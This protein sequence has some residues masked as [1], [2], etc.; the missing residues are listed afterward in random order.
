MLYFNSYSIIGLFLLFIGL[1]NATADPK[2]LEGT[3]STKSNAVFTGPDFYDPV[4]ELLIEPA[5]PGI[6]FSFTKL[7]S[8]NEGYFE[9]SIYQVTSNAKDP[10]CP[11]A[12]LIF[13]H[14]KYEVLKNNSIVLK[15]FE[16]DGRQ[17]L[18]APCN[19]SKSTYSRYNQTEQY[20][21]FNVYVDEYHGRYR[22]DLYK[23]DGSPFPPFYLSYKPPMMLPTETLNPTEAGSSP[24]NTESTSKRVKRSLENRSKTPAVLKHTRDYDA[25]WWIGVVLIFFGATG[26]YVL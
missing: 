24:Q 22:L 6:S 16:V 21:K 14:G 23:F 11:S 5:L 18:S 20:S 25:M 7:D 8:N 12:V 17:L 1:T 4:D 13:Q 19:D 9:E 3:W 10:T 2:D 26:W 15:P